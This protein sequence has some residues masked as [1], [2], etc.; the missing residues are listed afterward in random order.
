[1]LYEAYSL[2]VDWTYLH[3][4]HARLGTRIFLQTDLLR[5]LYWM[6]T[7]SLMLVNV[8]ISRDEKQ[9]Y[10]FTL[11]VHQIVAYLE[12]DPDCIHQGYIVSEKRYILN[13]MNGQSVRTRQG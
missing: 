7:G 9:Y 13:R 10:L 12:E 5:S 8:F 4:Y 1:M 11:Q 3:E 2:F 6:C